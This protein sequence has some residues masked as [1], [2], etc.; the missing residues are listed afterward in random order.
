MNKNYK[1]I[2][3]MAGS[4]V[5]SAVNELLKY[6]EKGT[7]ASGDFNGTTLYSDTV[8]MDDAYIK[9]VGKTKDELDKSQ[10]VM[11][12]RCDKQEEKIPELSLIWMKKGRET[13]SSDKW[14]LWDKI[15]PIRLHDLYHGM[16]LGCCLDI[17]KILNNGGTLDEAKQELENQ[18]HSGTSHSLVCNMVKEFCEKGESLIEYI[19]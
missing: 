7:L 10:Q 17:I 16:E 11:R 2:R 8:T 18:N 19:K 6:K 4:D 13:L 1:E 14:E 15:V 12:E 5:E 3:F 9:I